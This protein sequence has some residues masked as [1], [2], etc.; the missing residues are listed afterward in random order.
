ME[1]RNKNE[2]G[3]KIVKEEGDGGGGGK[4]GRRK[5]RDKRKETPAEKGKREEHMK[6]IKTIGVREE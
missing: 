3:V 4:G 1:R 2:R 5:G 6:P